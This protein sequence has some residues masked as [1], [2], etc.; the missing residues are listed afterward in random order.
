[1]SALSCTLGCGG[2]GWCTPALSEQGVLPWGGDGEGGKL[3]WAAQLVCGQPGQSL[4][5]Q[6]ATGEP[7]GGGGHR[8]CVRSTAVQQWCTRIMHFDLKLLVA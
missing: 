7:S 8:V 4:S 5:V 1:M 6:P 2:R 3:R